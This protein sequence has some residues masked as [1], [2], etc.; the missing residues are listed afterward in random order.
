MRLGIERGLSF[1]MK[2][3]SISLLVKSD[4]LRE[5]L[6]RLL[7]GN[8]FRIEQSLDDPSELNYDLDNENHIIILYLSLGDA[9]S[10][11]LCADTI[12]RYAKSK[13]VILADKFDT[14]IMQE[15][16]RAGVCGYILSDTPSSNL[17]AM[18]KLVSM[19][20]NVVPSQFI[21]MMNKG[22]MKNED[23]NSVSISPRELDLCDREITILDRLSLGLSNK[24]I[25]R[26]LGISEATVKVAIKSIYRKLSVKNRTQ[27]AVLAR[28]VNLLPRQRTA[29]V[30]ANGGAATHTSEIF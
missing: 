15:Y 8:D 30:S 12:R 7:S 1:I 20:E 6:C 13:S 10:I 17:L 28:E 25:S 16:F 14:H 19:G 11:S 24:M 27:A 5:G 29:C 22:G 18:I 3:C 4:L 9:S 2:P 21:E 23:N 26:D